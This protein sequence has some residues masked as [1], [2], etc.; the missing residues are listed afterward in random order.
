MDAAEFARVASKC[1]WSERSLC[2]VKA[3]IVDDVPL[4]EV[5]SAHSI[6]PQHATVIRA[7]F[8]AKAEKLRVEDFMRREKPKLAHSSLE[9][10]SAQMQTLRD[11]G[12]TVDQ[13]VVYLKENG[14]STSPTT[15]RTFLRSIRAWKLQFSQTR[16]AALVNL[17]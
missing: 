15:V 10:Y 8:L 16:K 4:S 2:V 13:I 17:P 6:S 9:P 3:L 1:K 7:R 14:V 5:A 12:Y 11:K